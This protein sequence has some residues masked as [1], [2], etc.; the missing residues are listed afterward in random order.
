SEHG[1]EAG[2]PDLEDLAG[3][4]AQFD[5]LER[6]INRCIDQEGRVADHATPE[7]AKIRASLRTLRQRVRDHLDRLV[8]SARGQRYLQE[9]IVTLRSGRFVVPVKQEYRS[10]IPGIVHDQSSSGATL[11]V[12][13]LAV[14]E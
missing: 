5:G 6:E 1:E 2:A 8:R 14:V 13:P 3:A 10:E 4:M 9:P 7:L 12:E 11:F